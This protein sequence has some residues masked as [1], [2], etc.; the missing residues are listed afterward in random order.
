MNITNK[1]NIII[2]I[3]SFI[4]K[5]KFVGISHIDMFIDITYRYRSWIISTYLY[6]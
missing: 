1:C 4:Y 6:P 5:Y 3:N 2:N